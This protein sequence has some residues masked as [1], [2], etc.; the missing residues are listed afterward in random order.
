MGDDA[1]VELAE[2]DP[3]IACCMGMFQK[4]NKDCVH[5]FLPIT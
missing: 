3:V 2:A 4:F 1:F 5:Q